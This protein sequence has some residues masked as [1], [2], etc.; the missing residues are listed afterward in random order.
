MCE[1]IKSLNQLNVF[2]ESKTVVFV[3][4]YNMIEIENYN[5]YYILNSE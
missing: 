1:I 3:P 2:I 4:C 5:K